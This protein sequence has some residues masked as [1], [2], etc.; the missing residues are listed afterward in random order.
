MEP[1]RRPPELLVAAKQFLGWDRFPD[2]A[3]QLIRLDRPVGY[4]FPERN[5]HPTILLFYSDERTREAL[6][7][8]FHEAGHYLDGSRSS[9]SADPDLEAEKRAWELG[10]E[11]FAEFCDRAELSPDWLTAYD[12]FARESLETYR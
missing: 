7:L 1:I 11:L 4:F 2:L 12:A 5:A 8:L 10:R 3:I 9:G 6:F